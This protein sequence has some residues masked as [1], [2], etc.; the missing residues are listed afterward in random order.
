MRRF[1]M[2]F[3]LATVAGFVTGCGQ[4]GS[5]QPSARGGIAVVDLDKVAAETG[6]DRQLAQS[7]NSARTRSRRLVCKIG[8]Q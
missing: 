3:A 2:A 1:E 4:F 6:R 7:L 8:G 5:S